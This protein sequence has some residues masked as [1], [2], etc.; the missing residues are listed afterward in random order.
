M[1]PRIGIVAGAGEMPERV[2]AACRAG[3]RDPFVI[4]LRDQA[5]PASFSR[6][7]DAWI[8]VGEAGEGI[9]LLKSA[10]AEEVVLVGGVSRP[11]LR[12]L[13]PDAWTA[14]FLARIGPAWFRDGSILDAVARAL[15][16][17]GL[18]V[19]AP[20][21]FASSLAARARVYGQRV[22]SGEDRA[23]IARGFE[24]AR[25]LGAL[26]VG[27]GT[28]VQRGRV[29][30]VEAAEGTDALIDRCGPL[31]SSGA[32]GV[33]VKASRPG[34]DLRIDLPAIGP[35]TVANAARIGLAGIAVEAGR[36]LI[37]DAEAV[38][39]DADSAGLFVIGVDRPG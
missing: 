11:S 35:R 15:E 34:Q 24:V 28:V 18:R 8:R 29:I 31:L 17:E 3:L 19:V 9:R 38:A 2:I 39:R 25:A 22:P 20:E 10:G 1:P 26:D 6:P 33:L 4:G 13:R 21:T 23:D 30:G 37:L 12:A 14:R 5:D 7:P 32:G 16:G 36:A 27:Q